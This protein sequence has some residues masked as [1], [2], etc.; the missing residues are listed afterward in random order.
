MYLVD[1]K[2]DIPRH[3]GFCQKITLCEELQQIN[4]EENL[5]SSDGIQTALQGDPKKVVHGEKG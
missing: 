2:F 5:S 3:F 1:S 4:K